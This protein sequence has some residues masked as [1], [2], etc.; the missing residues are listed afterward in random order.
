MS[1]ALLLDILLA[2][3]LL[4]FALIGFWRG[5]VKEGLATAGILFGASLGALWADRANTR[6]ADL[7]SLSLGASRFVV[8]TVGLVA[9]AIVLGYGAGSILIH[10]RPGLLGRIAGSVLAMVNGI[11]LFTF[12]L[13]WVADDVAGQNARNVLNASRFSSIMLEQTEWLFLAIAGFCGLMLVAA[14]LAGEREDGLP[15]A[16]PVLQPPAAEPQTGR[17]Y[18]RNPPR[19]VTNGD[20]G[21]IEPAAVG[22]DSVSQRYRSEAL[23]A[24][25]TVAFNRT[26][27]QAIE[28]NRR[29]EIAN[30][31][32]RPEE[33]ANAA[34]GWRIER[35]DDDESSEAHPT[36]NANGA[37]VIDFPRAAPSPDAADRARQICTAC[38]EN[39]TLSD[40]YCPSCGH[41]VRTKGEAG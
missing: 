13:R 30:G 17:G 38:G 34:V 18:R 9:C 8:S 22:F 2:T 35:F 4:L 32:F 15:A 11:L 20:S 14:M 16:R 23:D 36:E 24:R 31:S 6:I 40:E 5:V 10:E 29:V 3:I 37:G 7:T 19:P 1:D 12:W 25:N 21:K 39:I 27:P 33:W 41:A 26:D 28:S